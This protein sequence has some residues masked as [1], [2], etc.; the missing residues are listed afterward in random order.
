MYAA[1][2]LGSNSFSLYP[3]YSTVPSHC[4]I[5]KFEQCSDKWANRILKVVRAYGITTYTEHS[6]ILI[7]RSTLL[8]CR[9]SQVIKQVIEGLSQFKKCTFRLG[10]SWAASARR[11]VVFPEPGGPRRS[12]IL[13][14][15]TLAHESSSSNRLF[16]VW[17]MSSWLVTIGCFTLH[18]NAKFRNHTW[19]NLAIIDAINSAS[20]GLSCVN[21]FCQE[22]VDRVRGF[23][24][25][26][27]VQ[28]SR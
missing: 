1:V 26:A 6:R 5:D 7:F 18:V 12:V 24:L 8:I 10:S 16:G 20:A 22:I 11:K 4:V 2:F 9:W 25:H 21:W 14:S 19:R 28:S 27:Y 3:L 23:N 17:I 13:H 15:V